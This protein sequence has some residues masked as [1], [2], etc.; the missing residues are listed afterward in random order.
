MCSFSCSA[1]SSKQ[2]RK[3]HQ[4]RRGPPE[5]RFSHWVEVQNLTATGVPHSF[6]A[7]Q[8]ERH[9][10]QEF[11]EC[12]EVQ[13]FAAE[14]I[15]FPAEQRGVRVQGRVW[16]RIVQLCVA[17]FEPLVREISE[18]IT[19]LFLPHAT[20]ISYATEMVKTQKKAGK[21]KILSL[22]LR[23]PLEEL[24]H[25]FDG[26]RIDLGA[27]AC[28]HFV[29]GIDPYPRSPHL[30]PIVYQEAAISDFLEEESVKPF[31]QLEKFLQ[32]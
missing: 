31:A 20:C 27:L 10:L 17:S 22:S 7:S 32:K 21:G 26:G 11:Y 4:K 25:P 14:V 28:A 23:D 15:L 1:P 24:P 30:P 29:L 3:K 2:T 18:E 16:G 13:A 6:S 19:A 5:L 12:A 9:W 8:E